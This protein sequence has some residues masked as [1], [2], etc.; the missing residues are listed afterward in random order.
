MARHVQAWED[1]GGAAPAPLDVAAAVMCGTTAQA[2]WAQRIKRQVG[3]EFDRVAGLLRSI[4]GKQG[5][6]KRADTEAILAILEEKRLEVMSQDEAGYLICDWQ[7]ISDQVRQLIWHDPRYQAIKNN[8]AARRRTKPV[9]ESLI[10]EAVEAD[11]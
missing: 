1:E 2:E 3:T 5:P 9:P 11:E 4:A 6:G 8:R 7:E 10:C